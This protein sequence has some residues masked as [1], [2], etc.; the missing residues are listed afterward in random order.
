[1]R[2]AAKVIVSGFPR[3][4]EWVQAASMNYNI[5]GMPA[6]ARVE[7]RVF[8]VSR[9]ESDA[10]RLSTY[11]EESRYDI[12][13]RWIWANS[14]AWRDLCVLLGSQTPILPSI[15]VLSFAD[16]GEALWD[17]LFRVTSGMKG[18][19]LEYII[20]GVPFS[21]QDRPERRRMNVTFLPTLDSLSSV[22]Q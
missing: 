15:I 19:Y 3:R 5:T 6:G 18:R 9:L 1:M 22:V 12:S 21:E 13:V 4:A 14:S 2:D 20:T 11:L 16:L 8:L 10:I 7:I 17:I